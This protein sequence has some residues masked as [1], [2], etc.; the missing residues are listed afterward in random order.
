MPTPVGHSLAG[1]VIYALTT[2]GT[3][4]L[5]FWKWGVACM[6]V[7]AL[8]DIDFFPA[9]F[10]DLALANRLHRYL[11]HTL[12][13]ALV[14]WL[15]ALVVLRTIHRARPLRDSL[16][17]FACLTSH[18]FLDLL[19]KDTRPPIGVPF[20]WPFVQRSYKLPVEVFLDIKKDAYT[21][22]FGLH[23]LRVVAHEILLF[24]SLLAITVVLKMR[25]GAKQ[26]GIEASHPE[27][28]P[29]SQGPS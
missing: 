3:H 29:T 17:L 1:A 28:K 4:L 2:K 16:V 24:G 14:A 11:T 12:L 26:K 7:A 25:F 10:G 9:L 8:A 23:N 22:I 6:F 13:F 21:E 19:G 18:I 27:G 15:M 20:L 5:R